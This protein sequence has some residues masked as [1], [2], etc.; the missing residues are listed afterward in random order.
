MTPTFFAALSA[1]FG[2]ALGSY[3]NVVLF[4][5]GTGKS[6]LRGRSQCQHCKTALRAGD[7]VPV[8]SYV[9]LRG[10]CRYCRSHISFQYPVVEIA[11]AVL[12][13]LIYLQ[14]PG[15]L[16]FSFWLLVWMILLFIAA[17]DTRY[18]IISASAFLPLGALALGFAAMQ[19]TFFSGIMLSAPLFVASLLSR[20]RAMGFGD[21]F[22]ELSLGWLLGLSA[23][24]TALMLAFW[25]G[26]VV[27][28]ALLLSQKRYTMK[29]EVPLAPFLIL[30]AAAVHFF[31]VDFFPSLPSL[32]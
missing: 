24:L 32:F 3:L 21:G 19:G 26:G 22:L 16:V 27:G 6:S 4:R 1:V 11:A 15:F 12:A 8:F 29:S 18:K 7:L 2:A 14:H 30:G 28:I 25:T 20:G 5:F 31:H 13:L 10:K 23:G 9:F 17:Y